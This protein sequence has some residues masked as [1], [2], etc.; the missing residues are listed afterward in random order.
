MMMSY[1][2]PLY[3]D[4]LVFSLQKTGG[5]SIYWESIVK[6]ALLDTSFDVTIFERKDSRQNEVRN[7]M[8][9]ASAK[10]IIQSELPLRVDEFKKLDIPE[11][12]LLH[13]SYFRVPKSSN[14][15]N[16]CTVHDF[17]CMNQYQGLLKAVSFYQIKKA[18]LK[19]S[20]IICISESTRRDLLNYIPEANSKQIEIIHQGY[21]DSSYI[22][23]PNLKR[24]NAVCFIG[25]RKS[26]Y[27]NFELAVKAVAKVP[28]VELR[29]IG[30]SLNDDERNLLDEMIPGRFT[31]Y[32]YPSASEV[33]NI[34]NRSIAL[35]YLSEYEGFG[36]PVL[37]S[38]A[39]GLP[40]IGLNISSIPEVAGDAALLL[41]ESNVDD[42]VD[43]INSLLSESCL[44]KQKVSQGLKRVLDFS[45]S[46]TAAKTL[47]YYKYIYGSNY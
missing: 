21:D 5:G 10:R 42:V 1:K 16:V 40:V 14:I 46:K 2:I 17:I 37:E 23:D 20:G 4:N 30:A 28:Q 31:N 22:Y 8:S 9:L 13:S 3:L 38:M 18:A 27:K 35:L 6:A 32:V 11:D 47:D 24:E 29:I 41:K 15:K 25:N 7:K 26:A 39:S 33:S 45:W 43:S 44:F 12:G 19:A 34:F 36:I